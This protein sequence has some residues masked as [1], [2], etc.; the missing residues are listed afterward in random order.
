MPR[1]IDDVI[2]PEKRNT[3]RDI[4]IPENRKKAPKSF[5]P[6]FR[7]HKSEKTDK[8]RKKPRK[9]LLVAGS[10]LILAIIFVILS[11]FEGGTL[12]YAPKSAKL[13]FTRDV[14]T[15]RK[16]GE[17][18][19][20][21]VVKLSKEK[22]RTVSATGFQ[23]VEKKAS[24]RIIVYNT[25]K[26]S[27]KFRATTRFE[28]PDGKVYQVQDA[29]TVPPGS[30]E[31]TVYA[32]KP[33]QEFNIGLSDFTLPGLKNTP[34]ASSIYARSKTPMSGGF[35][36]R[37][38][39][40]KP[41]DKAKAESEL[42]TALQEELLSEA[43]AQVPDGFIMFPNLSSVNFESLPPLASGNNAVL[44]VKGDFAGLIFKKSD[45]SENLA[46]SKINFSSGESVDIVPLESL[47]ITFAGSAP[48]D[49]AASGEI[50]LSVSGEAMAVWRID[51][52][53]LK[54][55]LSGRHK[56]EIQ[57]ILN[58]YPA[59]VSATVTVKPFWRN[60]FPQEETN[61]KIKKLPVNKDA[62]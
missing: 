48:R 10:I 20:Y 24:G 25:A 29:I 33:G 59:I 47:V 12:A 17:A 26:V 62:E 8:F 1:K 31:V 36:G 40:V 15:A 34:L 22:E 23:D 51:E 7:E 18:F 2:I 39:V 30:L 46:K 16:S 57:G 35:V 32:E 49:T 13:S 9:F 44:K 50:N 3:I 37:E 19:T 58:N 42:K 28:T 21:S 54:K 52:L 43:R 56:R 61:I 38:A 60:T 41:E 4:P 45:L 6:P 5:T 14:Y 11:V 55:D 27:K 53:A